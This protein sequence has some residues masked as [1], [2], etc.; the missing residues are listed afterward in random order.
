M[1]ADL[2]PLLTLSICSALVNVTKWPSFERGSFKSWDHLA[3]LKLLN[4]Q[5]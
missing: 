1:I 2:R 4:W 3:V 5:V